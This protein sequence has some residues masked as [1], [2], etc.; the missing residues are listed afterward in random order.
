MNAW[1][2]G[3]SAVPSMTAARPA[4]A[5]MSLT[6]HFRTLASHKL[7]T[8]PLAQPHPTTR[9]LR[10]NFG[11]GL[12]LPGVGFVAVVFAERLRALLTAVAFARK[13]RRHSRPEL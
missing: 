6:G 12:H 4:A 11:R 5:V 8:K 13:L 3:I 10:R 1:P 2:A 7:S 9:R